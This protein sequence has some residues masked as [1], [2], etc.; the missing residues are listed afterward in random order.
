M[1]PGPAAELVATARDAWLDA[2][3]SADTRLCERV[4]RRLDAQAQRLDGVVARLGRPS[5]LVALHRVRLDAL[6][7]HLQQAAVRLVQR[8]TQ[9]TQ[10]VGQQLPERLHRSLERRRVRLDRAQAQLALLDPALVLQRGYSWLVDGAGHTITSAGQTRP[11]QVLR[12][13][14]ASG[15]LDVQVRE[16]V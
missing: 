9:Q 13:T 14:L 12:A 5:S 1:C 11:G 8:R 16:Q 6:A 10:L 7:R 2:L 4:W 15:Q 3:A